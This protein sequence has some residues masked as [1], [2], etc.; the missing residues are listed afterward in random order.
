MRRKFRSITRAA[1]AALVVAASLAVLPAPA[2]AADW[3]QSIQG[4]VQADR[5]L[6]HPNGKVTVAACGAPSGDTLQA[7][8]YDTAGSSSYVNEV[9]NSTSPKLYACTGQS[10]VGKDGSLYA[11]GYYSGQSYERL[12]AYKD[13]TQKWNV[14]LP[15]GCSTP[16]SIAMGVN[17]NVYVVATGCSGGDPNRL[18]GYTPEVTAGTTAPSVVLNVVVHWAY[19]GAGDH[20][21]AFDDGLVVQLYNGLQ[22]FEYDGD[23]SGAIQPTRFATGNDGAIVANTQG[24]AFYLVGADSNE[25]SL[26]GSAG[27]NVRVRIE[28]RTASGVD[29]T[30]NLTNCEH[31]WYVRPTYDGGVIASVWR[32][33]E[34]GDQTGHW[35]IAI[36][37]N[38]N[39]KWSQQIGGPMFD[40]TFPAHSITTTLNGDVLLATVLDDRNSNPVNDRRVAFNLYSG[41]TG[42]NIGHAALGGTT[43]GYAFASPNDYVAL[44]GG[45]IYTA[46]SQ[47]SYTSCGNNKALYAVDMTAITPS[48]PQGAVLASDEPWLDYV[49]LG[50]SFSSGEGVETFIPGTNTDGPPVNKCHRSERAY[51]RLFDGML[52][53]P[54]NLTNFVA[55]SGATSSDILNGKYNEVSQLNALDTNTKVVSLTAGGNDIGF[56]KFVIACIFLNC[57]DSSING[58]FFTTIASS[59]FEDSLTELYEEVL[60]N[61]PNA[62]VYILGYPQ[63]LPATGCNQTDAWMAA[64]SSLVDQSSP[65]G[66]IG[67]P[68]WTARQL[69]YKIGASA[70]LT[71][72][73]I[74]DTIDSGVIEF[75]AS[76]AAAARLLTQEL[77]EKINEAVQAVN[78]DLNLAV[79]RL[80]FVDPL[81][82]TSPF[83]GHELCSASPYFI[84]LEPPS[85][86]Y[87]FHPNALGQEAYRRLMLANL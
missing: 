74:Q 62:H 33:N 73:Q 36:D 23:T 14:R 69:V 6:A 26:C 58:P 80:H 41:A 35:L 87:S 16:A 52:G 86:E 31:V 32:H 46:L 77:D 25:Q 21:A 57:G 7:K 79:D 44:A 12:V 28:G 72:Q 85:Q 19:P 75:N 15:N 47:C 53:P 50:D 11:S 67:S 17:G 51:S 55:C 71:A 18:I 45:R 10:A 84:G 63:L 59:Q 2:Q 64:F 49:A 8:T 82:T 34:F 9:A 29:W 43:H 39:E 83:V 27:S 3:N 65:V 24:R 70:D 66:S 40:D 81:A 78:D 5:L 1:V 48:Y 54:L 56:E 13:N 38:G 76:E 4:V 61:A 68:S 20:L 30:H 37:G 42:Q 60:T 22:F